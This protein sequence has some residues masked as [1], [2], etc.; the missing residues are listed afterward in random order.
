[1][2]SQAVSQEGETGRFWICGGSDHRRGVVM[3]VAR[4]AQAA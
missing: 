3:E 1:M 2:K 4:A